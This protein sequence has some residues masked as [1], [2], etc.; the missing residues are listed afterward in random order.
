MLL[1]QAS[2]DKKTS[3]S[4]VCGVIV[5][6]KDELLML[7]RAKGK[8][9]EG[10]WGVP[11]G[12]QHKNETALV[13]AQR[14]LF[15]ET[16]LV[17]ATEDLRF[18]RAFHVLPSNNPIGPIRFCLFA[19][20]LPDTTTS[21]TIQP[22]EHDL[23]LWTRFDDLNSDTLLEDGYDCTQQIRPLLTQP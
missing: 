4:I 2:I 13:T 17:V 12:K 16:G 23:A 6:C 21:I 5:H 15:E 11:A 14:E 9:G 18:L 10:L 20:A 19:L 7:R 8:F 22:V 1:K 3:W